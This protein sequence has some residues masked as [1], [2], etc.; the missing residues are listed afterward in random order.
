MSREAKKARRKA[1]YE[2]HIAAEKEHKE[3]AWN[4][5]KIILEHHTETG[6]FSEDFSDKLVCRLFD[7][8]QDERKQAK[9][10]EDWLMR[11]RKWKQKIIVALVRYSGDIENPKWQYLK[12]LMETYYDEVLENE[13]PSA[14]WLI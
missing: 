14:L 9:D 2:K 4:D 1:R 7:Y 6:T 10:Q 12:K 8:L 13:N 11:F 3:K 5:G